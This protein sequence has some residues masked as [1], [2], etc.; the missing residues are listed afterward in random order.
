MAASQTFA[1]YVDVPAAKSRGGIPWY[2]WCATVAV[3]SVM[4]GGHWDVSW[5][6]SIG[7]DTFWT[8]A[9]M[10]IY[11][12]GVLSGLTFGYLILSTTFSSRS[13]LRHASVNIWGFRA[14]LGAFIASWGGITMLTSA[15]FDNWW[16]DAYGLDVKI[17]SPP[18]MLLFLG[19]YGVLIGTLVLIRGYANRVQG[20]DRAV[21]Q[22]LFLYVSG[23]TLVMIM[24][25]IME[26]TSR[27]N[28]HSSTPYIAVSLLAPL[29]LATASRATGKRFPA[30]V[31]ASIYTAMIVGLILILPLFPAEPKLGPVYQH[32]TQFIPPQ[33]PILLIVPAVALDL[34]WHR[35]QHWNRWALAA[36]SGILFVLLLLAV[37]W[38]F[39]NFLMSPAARNWFFGTKYFWYGLPP[40][41]YS[42]RYLFYTPETLLVFWRGIGIAI[43]AA[44]VA[45][46]VGL[47]R[48]EWLQKVQR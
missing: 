14:P 42:A 21:A 46:R 1:G 27:S 28:L 4:I 29:S 34:L 26:F 8:P 37:E 25:M 41:S 38:P 2:I 20:K 48:G 30:T 35:T 32:V 22:W 31:V 12:C 43:L 10:A 6:S 47:S 11:L 44:V 23:M 45:T 3:T 5:H 24:F 39:A 17:V 15:P 9:H 18:H 16:H 40:G 13:P 7:R 19:V 36:V 33:F